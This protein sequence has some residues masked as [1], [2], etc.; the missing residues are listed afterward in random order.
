MPVAEGQAHN[1]ADGSGK[2]WRDYVDALADGLGHNGLRRT[3]FG[4]SHKH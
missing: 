3:R 4:S 2:T 1:I